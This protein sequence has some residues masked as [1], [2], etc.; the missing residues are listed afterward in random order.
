MDDAFISWRHGFNL[1]EHGR[2]SFN[3]H[4]EKVE[5]ATS[6]L[7]G[8]LSAIPTLLNLDALLFFK[9][10]SL[11][12]IL[13]FLA[14]TFRYFLE[15]KQPI[16]IFLGLAG[17]VQ[18]IHLWSGLE[19]SYFVFLLAYLMAGT[20]G[21]VKLST[22]AFSLL[23]LA[24]VSI[25]M[26][27]LLIVPFLSFAMI[28]SK[29]ANTGF[30]SKKNNFI[31]VIKLTMPSII[32]VAAMSLFRLV[33]FGQLFPNTFA[34]KS[35]SSLVDFNQAATFFKLNS[36]T[37][38]KFLVFS[39]AVILIANRKY[40]AS[41]FLFLAPLSLI[42]FLVYAPSNLQMN[43][44][45]RFSFQIFW[46]IILVS[47]A[48]ADFKMN[49]KLFYKTLVVLLVWLAPINS[50]LN[51][52]ITNLDEY[53]WWLSYY[54]RLT[55]SYGELGKAISFIDTSAGIPPRLVIGDIGLVSYE[56]ESLV[57]DTAFKATP[58]SLGI[59][60][61]V[62][63]M[64]GP[65][66]VVVA[67]FTNSERQIEVGAYQETIRRFALSN[68]YIQ[69]GSICWYPSNWLQ[70]WISSDLS[71]DQAFL[72]RLNAA[73]AKSKIENN[74]FRPLQKDVKPWYWDF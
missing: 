4:G 1:V 16:L 51:L 13:A 25:R 26:E 17:P 34:T 62:K 21:I 23:V 61:I 72:D 11:I 19:T 15:L 41:L 46:P 63:Q 44:M 48:A 5:A 70:I 69:V 67:F 28:A 14:F 32:L 38:F 31:N 53:N 50:G 64:V 42:A 18:A 57:L 52:K 29:N 74:Q 35:A 59:P 3:A 55:A 71:K 22:R 6:A 12:M 36:P 10:C 30:V 47:I 43:Y 65:G 27:A 39:I 2:Y 33:Y 73:I 54:P 9:I 24:L 7:F 66:P 40:R 60:G 58:P 49:T 8:L 37:L 56:N 20:L 45:N 68:K